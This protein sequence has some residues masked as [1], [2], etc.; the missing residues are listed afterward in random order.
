MS[1][2]IASLTVAVTLLAGCA[3]EGLDRPE[4]LEV[5]GEP[6]APGERPRGI[7]LRIASESVAKPIFA[8]RRIVYMNREGGSFVPG[9]DDSSTNRSSIPYGSSTIAPWDVSD[10]GWQEVMDCMTELW[11]PFDVEITD[12]EPALDV[13]YIESVVAGWPQDVGM[14]SG[15]GGVSPF[16]CGVIERSIVF[17]FA[18]VYGS[19]Y[20]DVCETA[21][22]ETAHSFGLDHE[23]LCEDPMTYLYGC[24]AKSF[25]D[26]DAPCG[27]YSERS[28]SCGGSTQNSVTIL[29]ALNG[30]ADGIPP[31]VSILS[32]RDG[33]R[34]PPGFLVEVAAADDQGVT[35]VELHIDG[36]LADTLTQPPWLFETDP[37]LASGIHTVSTT[38][39]DGKN[40]ATAQVDVHITRFPEDE[41][42]DDPLVN[43]DPDVG[44][45]RADN[46]ILGGCRVGGSTGS[47]SPGAV[48]VFWGWAR[49][50]RRATRVRA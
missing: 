40:A 23:Y 11:S 48:L 35:R 1:R 46:V 8:K 6:A 21:A 41:L 39:H 20:R 17:T 22:Q 2:A 47:A 42:P 16:E 34:V 5:V 37:D 32:P 24:G 7:Y 4:I 33:A 28:C 29:T 31:T 13:E 9:Y 30:P 26:I 43:D 18:E 36:V 19:S 49:R 10:A 44:S 50:R 25:Q 14:G 3:V 27:E 38:A 45:G 15:V 12:I